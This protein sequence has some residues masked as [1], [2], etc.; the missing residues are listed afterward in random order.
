MDVPVDVPVDEPASSAWTHWERFA[1]LQ[2]LWVLGEGIC[3]SPAPGNSRSKAA[4][5]GGWSSSLFLVPS[6]PRQVL[7][8]FLLVLDLKRVFKKKK[9]KTAQTCLLF[10]LI[11]S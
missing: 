4:L 1:L 9:R 11:G 10:F 8:L 7:G 2:L 6:P 3:S 5:G